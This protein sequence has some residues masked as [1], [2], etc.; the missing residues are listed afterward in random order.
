MFTFTL[1]SFTNSCSDETSREGHP[2]GMTLKPNFTR[3]SAVH[4][5]T[6]ELTDDSKYQ[7]AIGPITINRVNHNSILG[8]HGYYER[9][10]PARLLHLVTRCSCTRSMLSLHIDVKQHS[11]RVS[12]RRVRLPESI[13]D[14][15]PP[16]YYVITTANSILSHI[17]YQ[18][19]AVKTA[20]ARRK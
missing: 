19:M 6:V 9:Q 17:A 5:Q 14:P 10:V 11:T 3:W 2:K 8:N 16:Q 4:T 12:L 7:S 1:K 13:R 20:A 18:S 15:A